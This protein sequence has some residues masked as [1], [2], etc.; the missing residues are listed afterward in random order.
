MLNW[1]YKKQSVLCNYI[2]CGY[3]HGICIALNFT[4][5]VLWFYF[6]GTFLVLIVLNG[7]NVET[8]AI[9][10]HLNCTRD[11]EILSY[12]FLFLLN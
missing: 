6:P 5:K 11:L 12:F 10:G 4:F 2:I 7:K 8:A 9:G 1:R 3:S